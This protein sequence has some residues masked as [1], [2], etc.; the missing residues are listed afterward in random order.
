[1]LGCGYVLVS[2]VMGHTD[3][4]GH[5][6]AG[7]DAGGHGGDSHV[8]YGVDGGGHGSASA[9]HSGGEFHFPFFSPLALSTLFGA[10][11]AYGL[12]ALHGLN[13]EGSKSLLAALPAALLTTYVVTYLAWRLASSSQGSS[14]IRLAD[15][16]GA[17][18]EVITPI[19]ANGIGEVAAMVSGQRYTAASR[20]EKGREVARGAHVKVKAMVG[21]TLLVTKGDS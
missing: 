14:Q 7:G 2:L 18:A 1:M 6:D 12:I 8:D 3:F 16:E 13:M 4:G 5:G 20:E 21:T 17:T 10:V 19:P 15:L 11:G 9:G